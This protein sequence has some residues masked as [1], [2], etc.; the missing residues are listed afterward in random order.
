MCCSWTGACTGPFRRE[1]ISLRVPLRSVPL[2]RACLLHRPH[3]S[4]RS[5][6]RELAQKTLRNRHPQPLRPFLV[7]AMSGRRP[8]Y[9]LRRG[10]AGAAATGGGRAGSGKRRWARTSSPGAHV[11]P[12][13]ISIPPNAAC[14]SRLHLTRSAAPPPSTFPPPSL[15]QAVCTSQCC[16]RASGETATAR[17]GRVNIGPVPFLASIPLRPLSS[18]PPAP[19]LLS[20]S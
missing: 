5:S 9:P 12:T 6:S 2:S 20:I 8:R 4:S 14:R 19:V 10:G 7:V 1:L 18:L 3:L 17:L 11:D 15:L 13:R 16:R